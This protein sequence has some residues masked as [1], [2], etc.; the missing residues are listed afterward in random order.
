MAT[1]V[2]RHGQAIDPGEPEI[3]HD[4]VRALPVDQR[5][6]VRPGVGAKGHVA[7]T[8]R[9][10]LTVRDEIRL[11]IDHQDGPSHAVSSADQL[12]NRGARP[13]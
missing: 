8:P 3:G 6:R 10:A 1:G 12:S 7:A 2:T 5:H 11:V 13:G 4:Q 9:E